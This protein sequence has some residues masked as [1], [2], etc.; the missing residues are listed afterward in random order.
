MLVV[1]TQYYAG[2]KGVRSCNKLQMIANLQSFWYIVF[3]VKLPD[4]SYS[5]ILSIV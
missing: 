2:A 3:C 4:I 1:V 5:K